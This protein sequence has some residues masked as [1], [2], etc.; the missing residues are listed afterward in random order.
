M[1]GSLSPQGR[2]SSR[3][4][5]GGGYP[6]VVVMARLRAFGTAPPAEQVGRKQAF[7]DVSV[8]DVDAGSPEMFLV[9][10]SLLCPAGL[11]ATKS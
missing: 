3:V 11:W 4:L 7:P 8:A 10:W 5:V 2:R 6:V 1:T 9:H